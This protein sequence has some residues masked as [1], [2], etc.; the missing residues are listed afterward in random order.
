MRAPLLSI[1]LLV[2]G[3]AADAQPVIAADELLATWKLQ[4]VT[5][6]TA[7][8]SLQ[9]YGEHPR[10]YLIHTRDDRAALLI[11]ADDRGPTGL[12]PPSAGPVGKERTILLWSA[13][14]DA[15]P[16]LKPDTHGGR[17]LE[18][19]YRIEASSIQQLVGT[20]MLIAYKIDADTL[21]AT[22]TSHP[23]SLGGAVTNVATWVRDK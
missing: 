1:L 11:V 21:V 12:G 7:G 3:G 22:W 17:S 8:Q 9:P 20:S 13:S 23:V 5:I 14:Y 16:E 2:S 15:D 10:G 6:T 4:A 19:A 18:V